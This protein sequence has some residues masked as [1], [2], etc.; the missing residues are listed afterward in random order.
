MREPTSISI[1]LAAHA[2]ARK[3]ALCSG[4]PEQ[5]GLVAVRLSGEIVR[6]RQGIAGGL[7]RTGEICGFTGASSPNYSAF[8]VRNRRFRCFLTEEGVHG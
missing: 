7:L 2:R 4:A 6:D 8:R 3:I 1:V 5:H